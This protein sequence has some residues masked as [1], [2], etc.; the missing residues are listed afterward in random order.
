MLKRRETN[1]VKMYP[2]QGL[3]QDSS[4]G[5]VATLPTDNRLD[6]V[7]IAQY[8]ALASNVSDFNSILWIEHYFTLLV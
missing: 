2:N 5:V 3:N 6:I 1:K 8:R 4:C 7:K